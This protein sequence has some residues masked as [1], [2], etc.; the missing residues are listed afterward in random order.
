MNAWQKQY[1]GWFGGCNGVRVYR[2]G[3]FTLLPFE[4]QCNGVQFLQIKMPKTRPYNRPAGGGGSAGIDNLDWYYLELR[5]PLD[6]DG[7]LGNGT[8]TLSPRVLVH[9]GANPADTYADG[10][11][12]VPARHD[13]RDDRQLRLERRRAGDGADVQRSGRRAE[14]HDDGAER[15]V[16]DHHGRRSPSDSGAAPTCLDNSAFTAPGP[17]DCGGGAGG[18][19]GAGGSGGTGGSAAAAAPAGRGGAAAAAGIGRPAAAAGRGG[20]AAAAGT[21]ARGGARWQRRHA[22]APAAAR[23][24]S[25]GRGG[26]GGDGAGGSTRAAGWRRRCGPAARRHRRCRGRGRQRRQRR[27]RRR[28][29]RW[30]SGRLRRLD[31]RGRRRRND[32]NGRQR[33]HD[34]RRR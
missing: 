28:R 23:A 31:G 4:P 19:G 25:A 20:A 13:P 5:T 1:Q 15:A 21:A 12:H 16:G 27:R 26:A 30:I 3:T 29:H 10:H 22:V 2:S 32:R 33:R 18:R 7:T 24:A 6:F 14:L 8:T 17:I 11:A 9:V 34:R